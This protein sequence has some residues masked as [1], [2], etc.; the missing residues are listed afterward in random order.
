MHGFPKEM[1]APWRSK[2]SI[3]NKKKQNQNQKAS[4]VQIEC[5]GAKRLKKLLF[6]LVSTIEKCA[7]PSSSLSILSSKGWEELVHHYCGFPNY[8]K[9]QLLLVNISALYL[10]LFSFYYSSCYGGQQST[11]ILQIGIG[12]FTFQIVKHEHEHVGKLFISHQT[13]KVI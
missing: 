8:K 11:S 2:T 12:N 13:A 3:M 7:S 6:S 9:K 4:E 10:T 1:A 5:D